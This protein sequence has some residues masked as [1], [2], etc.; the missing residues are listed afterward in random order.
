MYLYSCVIRAIF[1]CVTL[2]YLL[3]LFFYLLV[4]VLLIVEFRLNSFDLLKYQDDVLVLNEGTKYLYM[5]GNW[6]EIASLVI[7]VI[8]PHR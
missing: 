8:G 3:Y 7:W 1:V 2:T 5:S 4:E 6:K